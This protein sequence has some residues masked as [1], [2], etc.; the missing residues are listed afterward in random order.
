MC[1]GPLGMHL[2]QVARWGHCS[3][4]RGGRLGEGEQVTA[5]KGWGPP[6]KEGPRICLL[7]LT[8]TS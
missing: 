5:G 6:A 4:G 8:W 2:E 7:P 1:Q 3:K